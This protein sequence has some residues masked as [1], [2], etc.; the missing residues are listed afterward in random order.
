[1]IAWLCG[2]VV[3]IESSFVVVNVG[4]VGYKVSV[5]VSVLAAISGVGATLTLHVH[6]TVREDDIALYGFL[7]NRALKLFE[8]LI[9]VTGIGPKVA[10][11]MLSSL[12][13]D[14]IVRAVSADDTRTL[15]RVPG[16]GMKTAQRLILELRDKV[17]TMAWTNKLNAVA[18][19]TPP[20][21]EK[22]DVC[23]DVVDGL[24]NLGFNRNEA[25]RMA[26]RA[27]QDL[28]EDT[29]MPMILRAALNLLTNQ[30]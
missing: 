1:M 18:G 9:A 16:L 8:L 7:D 22:I 19:D 5:P 24:V 4:G 25:R 6:T 3:S 20:Q 28:G 10:L 11:S 14:E 30:K 26:E 27:I 29:P 23:A 2:D 17:Q 21:P 15:I 13:L 12:E